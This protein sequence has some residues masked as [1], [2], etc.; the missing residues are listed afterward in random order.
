MKSVPFGTRRDAPFNAWIG[1][2]AAPRVNSTQSWSTSTP[3]R[4]LASDADANART[5]RDVEALAVHVRRDACVVHACVRIGAACV[6]MACDVVTR[7]RFYVL[8]LVITEYRYFPSMKL[9]RATRAR[10][11]SRRR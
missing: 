3:Q 5:E 8:S 7:G 9:L 11:A 6:D 1:W 2:D 10:Y 4:S